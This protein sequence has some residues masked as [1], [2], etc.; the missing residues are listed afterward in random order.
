MTSA[1]R[2]SLVESG[3]VPRPRDL[4]GSVVS[5]ASETFTVDGVRTTALFVDGEIDMSTIPRVVDVL[6]RLLH[7]AARAVVVD[8]TGV[9]FCS[10]SGLSA[11]VD[12]ALAADT[13]DRHLAVVAPSSRISRVLDLLRDDC[14]LARYT[15]FAAAV[16]GIRALDPDR[17]NARLPG[18]ATIRRLHGRDHSHND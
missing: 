3:M 6:E 11:V 1:P 16:A 9:T 8:L 18:G 13:P 2:L 17:R 4:L 10:I 7:A 14:D 5:C 12:V 15:T